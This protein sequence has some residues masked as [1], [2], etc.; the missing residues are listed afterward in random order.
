M[1]AKAHTQ[2]NAPLAIK[3]RVHTPTHP[4]ASHTHRRGDVY[5]EVL[6][7][8]VSPSA[9]LFESVVLNPVPGLVARSIGVGEAAAAGVVD[10][11]DD[12]SSNDPPSLLPSDTS[13]RLFVL[14]PT[15]DGSYVPVSPPTDAAEVAALETTNS[16][17]LSAFPPNYATGTVLPLGRL[18]IAWVAGQYRERGRFQTSMLNRRTPAAPIAPLSRPGT[19]VRQVIGAGALPGSARNSLLRPLPAWDFDLTV[20][21]LRSVAAEDE[22]TA[23][24]SI[25][26]R[27]N[28]VTDESASP[29]PPLQLGI[30]L[31]SP[32]SISPPSVPSFHVRPPSRVGTPT[33]PAS[34]APVARSPAPSRP[35]TPVSA[36]LRHAAVSNIASPSLSPTP[37]SSFTPPPPPPATAFPPAPVGGITTKRGAHL[38]P[39][40]K[41][42]ALGASLVAPSPAEWVLTRERAGTTYAAE[43][44]GTTV[45]R[46]WEA[47]Y[48]IDVKFLALNEGLAELGGCRVLLMDEGMTGKEWDSLGD[49]WVVDE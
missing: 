36:Q 37:V 27:S 42:V 12:E 24:L 16:L 10:L 29:P 31:L 44:P 38:P 32:A 15:D 23:K 47:R 45:H 20:F 17:P 2:V 9:M 39:T 3:T 22:F 49:V 19:P 46:R 48:E 21:S 13:Q 43:A 34:P 28:P 18:D 35:M 26:V 41:V 11:A 40:G 14:S 5:L 6:M 8:N 33:R 30:Q 4:N 7:Q 1:V 25:A